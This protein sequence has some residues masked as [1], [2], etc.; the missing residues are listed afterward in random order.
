[1]LNIAHTSTVDSVRQ[2]RELA[3]GMPQERVSMCISDKVRRDSYKLPPFLRRIVNMSEKQANDEL[4][5]QF[6]RLERTEQKRMMEVFD[7][8][9]NNSQMLDE[10]GNRSGSLGSKERD[11]TFHLGKA[12]KIDRYSIGAGVE[13]GHKN[14]YRNIY[15]FE[16]TR[17][18][19]QDPNGS[20]GN[21]YVNANHVL[22]GFGFDKSDGIAPTPLYND[23]SPLEAG[24]KNDKKPAIREARK[25]L[26]HHVKRYIATQGPMESTLK[27][28]WQVCWEQDV[29]LIIM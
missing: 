5:Y 3:N 27:D 26:K 20:D 13:L 18:K 28:F 22:P 15:P 16:H 6:Y 23:S 1:M 14:R 8:L 25:D 7:W 11:D 21:S 4:A 17:V 12:R 2:N 10:N 29:N 24:G 19:L 9:S